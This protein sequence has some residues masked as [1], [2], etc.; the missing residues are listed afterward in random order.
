MSKLCL[1][2]FISQLFCGLSLQ[3][4]VF[5]LSLKASVLSGERMMIKMTEKKDPFAG[6]LA[7]SE[8]AAIWKKYDSVLRHHINHGT[9]K[10]GVEAKKFGKQ[11]V[12]TEAAMRRLYGDPPEPK[13]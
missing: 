2:G 13:T 9:I 12:I 5:T 3:S 7:L 10:I 8:A 4:V 1:L 6:L 11:W